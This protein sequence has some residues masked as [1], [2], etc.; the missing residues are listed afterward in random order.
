[1][2]IHYQI[3]LVRELIRTKARGS[4][5]SGEVAAH[6]RELQRDPQFQTRLNVLLDLSECT[7]LPD[8]SQLEEIAGQL[9]DLGGRGRFHRCAIV[10]NRTALY[11]MTRMFEVL[12]EAQFVAT[13]VFQAEAEAEAWLR[14][15]KPSAEH[16]NEDRP[17]SPQHST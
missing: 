13:H 12:A 1:M 17:G 14:E 4:V 6:F 16:L 9:E 3:E 15:G 2:P 11:G 10:A 5:T 8:R 7:S